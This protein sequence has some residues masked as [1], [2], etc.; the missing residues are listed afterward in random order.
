MSE[1]P[2]FCHCPQPHPAYGS[3]EWWLQFLRNG[4][5]ERQEGRCFPVREAW[6]TTVVSSPDKVR[7]FGLINP[8]LIEGRTDRREKISRSAASGFSLAGESSAS[9]P[10]LPISFAG[11]LLFS[12]A[13]SREVLK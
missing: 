4:Q 2:C 1:I 9:F 3:E 12:L 13:G 6:E 7:P 5:E 11:F 10:S 8:R